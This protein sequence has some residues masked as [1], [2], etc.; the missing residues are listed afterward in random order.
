[1]KHLYLLLLL[2]ANAALGQVSCSLNVNPSSTC[3]PKVLAAQA[4]ASSPVTI[5]NYQWQVTSCSGTLIFQS[6]GA[7]S[8]FA[9]IGNTD[10]CACWLLRVKVTN[11][12]GDTCVSVSSPFT[13]NPGVS[14]DS[15]LLVMGTNCAAPYPLTLY[16]NAVAGCGGGFDS[17]V[18]D[19][20]DGITYSGP[21]LD[22]ISHIYSQAGCYNVIVMA[23][24]ILGCWGQRTFNNVC[25]SNQLPSVTGFVVSDDSLPCPNP[26]SVILF[27]NNRSISH[28]NAFWNFGD[29]GVSQQDT[30]N[31]IY[32]HPGSYPVMLTISNSC[33]ADS[34]YID[35]IVVGG[36]VLDS[37]IIT[38]NGAL[39]ICDS[40]RFKLFC[41]NTSEVTFIYGCN[42]GFAHSFVQPIGTVANPTIIDYAIP[43]CIDSCLPQFVLRDSFGCQSLWDFPLIDVNVLQANADYMQIGSNFEF[44]DQSTG[45]YQN[46]RWYF[47]DGDSSTLSDPMHTFLAPGNYSVTLIVTDTTLGC[48]DDT[49]FTISVPFPPATDTICGRTYIDVNNSGNLDAND[50]DLPFAMLFINSNSINSNSSGFYENV[51][52]VGSYTVTSLAVQG[53]HLVDPPAGLYQITLPVNSG[54]IYNFGFAADTPNAINSISSESIRITPNPFSGSTQIMVDGLSSTYSLQIMDLLGNEVQTTILKPHQAFLLHNLPPAV[55]LYRITNK[56]GVVHTGKLVS[57]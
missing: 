20:G 28:G 36:P 13:V 53:Y 34:A 42:T 1:M 24:G 18:V 55:Y 31:Y 25:F 5:I 39:C 8:A 48:T 32:A 57:Q 29:G 54:C 7:S 35:T 19:W 51:L 12:N 33:G 26:P 52:L 50:M 14:F 6:S 17:L 15:A 3:S 45:S 2:W 56:Y 49:V 22:S 16:P 9:Y 43:Y 21:Y 11:S 4:N 40:V 41:H 47:G 46:I 27:Q 10:S 38:G 44:H 37:V 30:T 23:H